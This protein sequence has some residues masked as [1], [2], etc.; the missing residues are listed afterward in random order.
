MMSSRRRVTAWLAEFIALRF[1]VKS[2]IDEGVVGG[3][4]WT[5]T[6]GKVL[7]VEEVNLSLRTNDG[8]A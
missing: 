8:L 7:A 6:V 5:F 1:A 4:L 3:W 2:G